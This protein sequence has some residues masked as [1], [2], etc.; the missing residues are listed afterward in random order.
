MMNSEYRSENPVTPELPRRGKR[1]VAQYEQE[2]TTR[3]M[4]GK[5]TKKILALAQDYFLEMKA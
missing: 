5:R 4:L 3:E 2:G 1:F